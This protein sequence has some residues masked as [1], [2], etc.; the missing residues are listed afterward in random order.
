MRT[1]FDQQQSKEWKTQLI[2]G[3]EVDP[4]GQA[5]TN[6]IQGRKST[7]P[8]PPEGKRTVLAPGEA[9]GWTGSERRQGRGTVGLMTR[10]YLAPEAPSTR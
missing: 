9:H 5:L 10:R 7:G 1:V 3:K 6:Y 2:T 4:L 8:G